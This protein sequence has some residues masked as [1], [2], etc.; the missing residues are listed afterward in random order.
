LDEFLD[1]GVPGEMVDFLYVD[2]AQDNLLIDALLL[3]SLCRNPD[4]L[5]WAGDTAQTISVGS[6]FRFNDLKAFLFRVEERNASASDVSRAPIPPRSFQLAVNYRSHGGIVNCAHSVIELITRLWP[7]AIDNLAQEKGIVDGLKP[8]FFHGWNSDTV[9]YEQFLFGAS[10]SHIEF[11][12]Q[13]CI[14]VRD[15]AARNKLREEVGD[16]GLIMTLYESKGLEFNDVLLYNFFEDSTV[17]VSQWRVILNALESHQVYSVAAPTFNDTRHAGVCSE[18]K[19]LYVAIT[20]ARK[21]MWIVDC[22]ETGEPM[23]VGLFL[24]DTSEHSQ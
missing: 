23:R 21:N 18:L 5:F 6:S 22:S 14:L 3:R 4:G 2:E 19:F 15:Q 17:D 16:I 12:A 7:H 20:R 13:Q 24:Q 9:R 8:I 1:R 11:G 10:G